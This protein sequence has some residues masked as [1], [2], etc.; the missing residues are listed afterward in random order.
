MKRD[1]CTLNELYKPL[2]DKPSVK[3][4][5]C[6]VC[7]RNRPL[8]E[9]HVVFRSAGTWV[10]NG[11]EKKKPTI[12]LCGFGNNAKDASGRL[13]CHGLAHARMLHFRNTDGW[14][15]LLTDEPT[16]YQDALE[17]EGWRQL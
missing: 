8:N 3:L 10:E 14:E 6:A 16:R 2:M 7:G 5:R 1:I 4:D 17:M 11:R 12:T 15:Y 9:H 13:Y